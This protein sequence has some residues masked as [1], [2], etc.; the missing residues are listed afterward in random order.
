MESLISVLDN[1]HRDLIEYDHMIS[2][3]HVSLEEVGRLTPDIFHCNDVNYNFRFL[4]EKGCGWFCMAKD[5]IINMGSVFVN[6]F[7]HPDTIKFEFPKIKRFCKTKNYDTVYSNYQQIFN[8][9]IR[10]YSVC[11][12]FIKKCSF[13]SGFISITK[14]IEDDLVYSKKMNRIIGE[15]IFKNNHNKDFETLTLRESE[16]LKFLA[17]GL[18]NPQI[19]AR[20]H[21]SRRTVEQHRKNINRKL[22]VHTYKDIISYAYAFDLV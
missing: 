18:N 20:L 4:N 21:I 9:S 11:L 10:D 6:K 8:P 12:V 3:N 2:V 13:L 1:Q 7:Y 17:E 5:H 16:I 22:D 19:S 15:E 14:P